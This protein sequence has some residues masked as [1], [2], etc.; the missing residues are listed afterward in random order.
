M[1]KLSLMFLILLLLTA[2]SAEA[3]KRKRGDK[4]PPTPGPTLI[5]MQDDGGEGFMLFDMVTGAYKCKLCEYD[6]VYTGIGSVKVE[7]YT[8]TFS[9]RDEGWTI[10]S[11]IDLFEQKGKCFVEVRGTWEPYLEIL[12][13]ADLRDSQASCGSSEPPPIETPSEV[14]LQNDADG[15]FL[16]FMPARGEFKFTYCEGNLAISGTGVV[17]RT[18]NVLNLEALGTDYRI[19]AG[20]DLFTK[21]GKAAIT[22]FDPTNGEK[23]MEMFISDANLTDNVAACGA[24]N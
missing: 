6:Y 16:L 2:V 19:L 8:V 5:V 15:S 18:G 4:L 7:G 3:Q 22:M 12:S 24:K 20:V 17:T 13:D 14:I 1:R 23:H 21:S 9:A 10:T 11:F